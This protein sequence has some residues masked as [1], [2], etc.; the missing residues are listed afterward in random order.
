MP[1]E[2]DKC[3]LIKK[4][5]DFLLVIRD[6]SEYDADAKRYS[7]TAF[8]NVKELTTKGKKFASSQM[9][10]DYIK[11]ASMNKIFTIVFDED[12]DESGDITADWYMEH[13]EKWK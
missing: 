9:K 7:S 2:F 1:K 4:E 8:V 3:V 11:S 5:E 12:I 10:C 13:L 6:S